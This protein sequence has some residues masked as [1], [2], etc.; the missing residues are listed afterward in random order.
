MNQQVKK[1]QKDYVEQKKS[2]VGKA[3]GCH[4]EPCTVLYSL[5]LNRLPTGI[6]RFVVEKDNK[7]QD[8]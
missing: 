5:W 7:Q 3:S 6:G 1:L 2:T 8:M 4:V